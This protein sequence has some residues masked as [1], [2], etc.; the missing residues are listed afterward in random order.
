SIET[1]NQNFDKSSYKNGL[2]LYNKYSRKDVCR[3]LNWENDISS[4][5]YGY[6]TRNG[7]TPCFVTYHKSDDIDDTINY[8]D[9]FITPSV[10]AWESRSN[11]K[12]SSQEIKNVIN[13]ERILLF[14]KKED[15]EGTDFYYMGDVSI[16]EDSI[17]QAE[18]PESKKPVVHFKFQLEQAVSTEL[19]NYMTAVNDKE[20]P[21]QNI[22]K[23]VVSLETE[24][25][26]PKFIIPFFDFYAAA[27]SFSELQAEKDYTEL[28]VAEKYS[29]DNDYFACKVIGESMNKRIPNGSTC[30]FKKYTGGSRNGKIVL[31]E[32]RDI[33]DPDFN[34]GFT[35]KTYSSQK[36][37]TEDDWGHKEI[38]LKPNSYDESFKDIVLD[39]D[40]AEGMK[41][42]GEFVNVLE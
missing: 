36:S 8:N 40:N 29:I 5:V 6:R 25:S 18:M 11:R 3:L 34:S 35:V 7:V 23:E 17:E 31:V 20:V 13:S 41:V 16:I 2:V 4:T 38:V 9:H 10:F 32:S 28:E 24:E 1:F 26:Q 30:I 39:E 33:H 42:I 14:V 15:A 12:L 19:Y 21:K 37:I 22:E 27:G